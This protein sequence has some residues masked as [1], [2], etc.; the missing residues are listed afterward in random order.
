MSKVD[1][2]VGDI[3]Q[4]RGKKAEQV[5]IACGLKESKA[6]DGSYWVYEFTTIDLPKANALTKALDAKLTQ[7]DPKENKFYLSGYSMRGEGKEIAESDVK[8]VGECK[9][10]KEVQVTYEFVKVRMI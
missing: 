4:V 8:I 3:V 7:S 5:V 1:M 9:L 6:Y 10:K 2:K